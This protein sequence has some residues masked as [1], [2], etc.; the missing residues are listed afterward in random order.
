MFRSEISSL[1]SSQARFLVLRAL[2]VSRE[3]LSARRL[4]KISGLAIRSV[5]VAVQGLEKEGIII[6]KTQGRNV[7]YRLS[8]A[9]SVR[10]PLAAIFALADQHD[11]SLRA[12]QYHDQARA[13]LEYS[14]EMLSLVR[15]ARKA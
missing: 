2:C 1:L 5:Q 7:L 11:L 10:S 4:E 3:E 6:K 13:S 15:L 8:E 9:W 14:N 12:A